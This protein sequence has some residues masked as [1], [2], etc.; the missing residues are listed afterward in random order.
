L[1]AAPDPVGELT[2]LPRPH[3]WIVGVL[4]LRERGMDE[5]GRKARKMRVGEERAGERR[6]KGEGRGRN[7]W[8]R[9][10]CRVGPAS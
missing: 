3:S 5:R 4:L 2:A 7:E 8:G 10:G 6:G 1:S 9:G